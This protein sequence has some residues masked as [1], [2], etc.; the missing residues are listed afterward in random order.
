MPINNISVF[1]TLL[2]V[3]QRNMGNLTSLF[4]EI[5]K[6]LVINDQIEILNYSNLLEQLKKHEIT[7]YGGQ[8]PCIDNNYERIIKYLEDISSNEDRESCKEIFRLVIGELRPNSLNHLSETIQ[9]DNSIVKKLIEKIN[10]EI[11]VNDKIENAI[12]KVAS[13]SDTKNLDDLLK[14]YQK[15]TTLKIIKH[16]IYLKSSF[17]NLLKIL[18]KE[19]FTIS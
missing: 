8:T 1:N 19:L 11:K 12:I 14:N 2:R 4:T 3:S 15:I 10:E 9:K 16:F 18:K 6:S 5:F 13:L 7:A 17:L